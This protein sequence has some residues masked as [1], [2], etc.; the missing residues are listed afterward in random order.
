[1]LIGV[2]DYGAGNLKNVCRALDHLNYS[3]LLITEK[4]HFDKVDKLIIPGVGAFAVAMQKLN[5]MG[6][7]DSILHFAKTGKPVLGICLG[8]Q[9]FFDKSYEFGETTGLGLLS[10]SVKAIPTIGSNGQVHKIPH[11]GWNELIPN[12]AS[13]CNDLINARD[14]VYFVHSFMAEPS[15]HNDVVAYCDYHGIQIPALVNR[16]NILGCQFHPEKSGKTGL[17]LFNKIMEIE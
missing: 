9:L 10:G 6:F 15:H 8:M 4:S 1:M 17:L 3:Y 14:S 11:I 16:D 2:L 12:S 7:I 5:E 13:D